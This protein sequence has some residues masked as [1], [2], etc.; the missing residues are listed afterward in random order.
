M[1]RKL[2]AL[3][4]IAAVCI[5]F[6]GCGALSGRGGTVIG[7]WRIVNGEGKPGLITITFN[8]D[9][10]YRYG[11]YKDTAARQGDEDGSGTDAFLNSGWIKELA[12]KIGITSL[13]GS[14]TVR[15]FT[16]KL[17]EIAKLTYE[18]KSGEER[19]VGV[20]RLFGVVDHKST[21]NYKLRGN[22]LTFDGVNYIRTGE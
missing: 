7:T 14:D 18:I 16:D 4:L 20:S 11:C 21:V 22:E 2:T 5:S 1:I 10:T 6:A 13:L 9:G 19:E 3:L 17:G 12:D 15:G 8:E